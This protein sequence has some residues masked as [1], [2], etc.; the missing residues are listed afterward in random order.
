MNPLYGP[1]NPSPEVQAASGVRRYARLV[2]LKPEHEESYR[3]M[4]AE[5]WPEVVVA[6]KRANMSNYSIHIFDLGG[7]KYLLA[8]FEYTGDNPA[9]DFAT[10]ATDPTTRDKWW[11]I[12]DAYQRRIA[13]TPDGEQWL[14][15][16]MVMHLP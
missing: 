8:Y 9:S 13:G 11:P 10:I 15:A 2:E 14:P 1:T 6:F 4:H 7:K 16:E 3:E 12:T 5:V